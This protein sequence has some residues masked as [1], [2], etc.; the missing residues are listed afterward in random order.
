MPAAPREPDAMPA[1]PCEAEAGDAKSASLSDT[2]VH[3][4]KYMKATAPCALAMPAPAL[5]LPL[6]APSP[7]RAIT[8]TDLEA[9]PPCIMRMSQG[10]VEEKGI[11]MK[12]EGA[13]GFASVTW[14][15]G[16][17]EPTE[18]SNLLLVTLKRPASAS[19][20][21]PAAPKAK[22]LRAPDPLKYDP[23]LARPDI[24][25]E[26]TVMYYKNG[27]N[28]GIRVKGE[29]GKQIFSF[30]GKSC[31]AS[32]AELREL[33]SKVCK[34]LAEGWSVEGAREWACASVA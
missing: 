2:I 4:K 26:H 28:I 14:P 33:G 20:K 30:G 12:G 23:V 32:E 22:I 13:A 21:K 1:T 24:V 11:L 8:W 29:G 16:S 27:H 3:M 9:T 34:K 5:A 19:L 18:V 6:P 15:D 7:A 25:L 31:K 17:V 10:G